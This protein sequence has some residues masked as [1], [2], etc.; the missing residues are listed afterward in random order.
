MIK[1]F[2][3][4][5]NE[6][7]SGTELVGPIGPAYGETRLQN[8]TVTFHDT[9]IILSEIDNGFYTIDEYNNIYGDYLKQ[10]GKPLSDGFNRKNLDI[11]ISFMNN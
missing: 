8:K 6:E 11:I 4:F 9:N 10:G 3:Q 2:K 1:S 5:I 7:V